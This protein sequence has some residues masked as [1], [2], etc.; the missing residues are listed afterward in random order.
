MKKAIF[1]TGFNNWGKSTIITSLFDDRSRFYYGWTYPINNANFQDKFTVES[2]SNDDWWGQGWID[3][4]QERIKNSPDNG[5]NIFTALCPTM[6]VNNNF[7]D[8]L[9][10]S[11]FSEYQLYIFLIE[12]KFE[13]HAKLLINNI[14]NAGQGIPQ[15]SFIVINADR[16]LQIEAERL[17][18]KLRQIRQELNKIFI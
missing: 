7:V 11:L 16:D 5:Q 8:L 18:A 9:N 10:K 3:R 14:I 12:Y 15:A 1:I 4:L 6:H 17:E 2:H 13:H